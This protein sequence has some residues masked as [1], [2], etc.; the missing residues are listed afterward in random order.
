MRES[1]ATKLSFQLLSE[2]YPL[3]DPLALDALFEA[4]NYN[5]SHT[6][7]ALEASL[8]TKPKVAE[9]PTTAA[10]TAHKDQVQSAPLVNRIDIH[11]FIIYIS[12]A[13]LCN[14]LVETVLF[15]EP[16]SKSRI[17]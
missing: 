5:Y 3:V 10:N 2:N 12:P 15:S 4:N 6:V 8:G 11:H 1:L 13:C 16:R 9:L 17:L 14:C 7:T